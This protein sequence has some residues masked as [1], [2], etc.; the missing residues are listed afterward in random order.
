MPRI[1]DM[2]IIISYV[3]MK[4]GSI[5]YWEYPSELF[6]RH[7]GNIT[8]ALMPL[9]QSW[10]IWVLYDLSKKEVPYAINEKNKNPGMECAISKY[11]AKMQ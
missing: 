7:M 11:Y 4:L 5:Q 2:Y 1:M 6:S 9:Q 8:T 10:R 3:F